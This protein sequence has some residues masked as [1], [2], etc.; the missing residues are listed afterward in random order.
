MIKNIVF[1]FGGVL[2]DWNPR[3]FYRRVFESEDE[4]EHFLAT[5]CTS[6][7][8][9]EQDR[10][11][12]LDEATDIKI[13]EFPEHE[14][15]IR[16]YY[17]EW[18]NMLNGTIQENVD[19]LPILKDKFN[20]YGLTNWSAET[21]PTALDLFDFFKEFEEKIVVSGV[22]KLIKPDP[23]I[24]QVLLNRYDIKAEESIFIDDNADNISTAKSLGFET[25]HYVSGVPV[26][27]EI[28]RISQSNH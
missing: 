9:I 19:L 20:L 1:D 21:F 15:L 12:S 24:F 25:I 27:D 26:K 11:R 2:V 7:W 23:A 5:I 6:D 17:D 10:G 28:E 18:V 3:Y 16:M 8:N 13:E 14:R 4:M 22:E